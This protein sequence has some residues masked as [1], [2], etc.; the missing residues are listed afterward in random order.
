MS[1][2]GVQSEEAVVTE[3]V[4]E[5][6][7]SWAGENDIVACELCGDSGGA[8]RL[9]QCDNRDIDQQRGCGT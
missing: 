6:L 7:P 5:Q 4:A 3:V 1:E 2:K 9:L 8:S